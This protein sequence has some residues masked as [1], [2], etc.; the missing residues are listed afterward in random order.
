MWVKLR[1]IGLLRNLLHGLALLY[2]L[3]LPFAQPARVL[4]GTRLFWG[5]ILPATAPLVF[6]VIMFDVLMCRVL[7][8]EAD[9]ERKRTLDFIVRVHLVLA[10]VLLFLWLFSFRAV[11]LR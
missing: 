1:S 8:G 11:L 10:F 9:E 4:V 2:I 5:G 7:R 6:V 3:L